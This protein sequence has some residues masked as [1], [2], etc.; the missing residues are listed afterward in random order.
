[1]VKEEEAEEEETI[2]VVITDERIRE[3]LSLFLRKKT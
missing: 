3:N 2:V 1:V